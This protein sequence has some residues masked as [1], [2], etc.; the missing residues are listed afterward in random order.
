M[1]EVSTNPLRTLNK[2]EL[3][4]FRQAIDKD[5]KESENI[6]ER[7]SELHSQCVKY[8]YWNH[9]TILIGYPENK[10]RTFGDVIK[11]MINEEMQRR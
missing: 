3:N 1:L 5:S 6:D 8:A 9:K 11:I 10:D 2:D 7:W 4:E